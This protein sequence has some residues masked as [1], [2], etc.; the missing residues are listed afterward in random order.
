MTYIIDSHLSHIYELK[1][2]KLR[3]FLNNSARKLIN[4]REM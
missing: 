2:Y 4:L 3:V 1:L